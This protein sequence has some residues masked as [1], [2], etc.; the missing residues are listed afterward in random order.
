M[1]PGI[2]ADEE[3]GEGVATHCKKEDHHNQEEEEKVGEGVIKEPFKDE[4]Y[5]RSL[6]PLPHVHFFIPCG[7]S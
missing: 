7:N 2:S 6:I 1:K 4:V 3:N 5:Q